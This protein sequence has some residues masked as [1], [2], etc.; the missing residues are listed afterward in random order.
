MKAREEAG[1]RLRGLEAKL[2]KARKERERLE[3]GRVGPREFF[4]QQLDKWGVWGE[5][6]RPTRDREGKELGKSTA[7]SVEKVWTA[8]EK[9][10]T[11]VEG[12]GGAQPAADGGGAGGGGAVGGAEG[13]CG[14]RPRAAQRGI[15]AARAPG[16][17]VKC[18][19]A[20]CEH[21]PSPIYATCTH[22]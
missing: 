4:A 7:K 2:L 22:R 5:D 3:E 20:G 19:I 8:R 15:D 16:C 6:G 9:G 17:M 21:T 1:A 11:G 18:G 14:T 10:H 13:G 12:E